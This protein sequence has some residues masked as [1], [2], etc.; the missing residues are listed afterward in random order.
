MMGQ[1]ET[2]IQVVVSRQAQVYCVCVCV[3]VCLC[4]CVCVCLCVRV[5]VCVCVCVCACCVLCVCLLGRPVLQNSHLSVEAKQ[6]V[7]HDVVMA[8]LLCGTDTWIIEAEYVK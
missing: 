5:C 7:Y 8:V 1:R 6:T 4:V 3:C 2:S